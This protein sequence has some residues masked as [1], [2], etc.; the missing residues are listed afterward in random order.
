MIHF[1]AGC[2]KLL[3]VG[4]LFSYFWTASTAVYFQLRRD[5]D[6]TETD[7]VCLDADQSEPT[8]DLPPIKNA[9]AGVPTAEGAVPDGT[10]NQ[11]E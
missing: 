7:E 2:V 5:V 11:R 3:A 9:P 8:S 1:W 10:A 6:H 4:Y